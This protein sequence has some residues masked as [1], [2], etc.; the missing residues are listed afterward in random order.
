[1]RIQNINKN[2]PQYCKKQNSPSFQATAC[3]ISKKPRT[4]NEIHTA[5]RQL[6]TILERSRQWLSTVI[7]PVWGNGRRSAKH[8]V[9]HCIMASTGINEAAVESILRKYAKEHGFC[10]KISP[11]PARDAGMLD[12][13]GRTMAQNFARDGHF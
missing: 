13:E 11:S 3:L 6:N 10:C 7:L 9:P 8:G 1:M 5:T 12:I 4:K 2:H